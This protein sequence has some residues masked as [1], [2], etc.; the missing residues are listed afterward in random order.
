LRSGPNPVRLS[1]AAHPQ[2]FGSND[3]RCH[4]LPLTRGHDGGRVARSADVGIVT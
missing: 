3:K 2:R 1:N 4:D